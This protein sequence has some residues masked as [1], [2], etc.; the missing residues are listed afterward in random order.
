MPLLQTVLIKPDILEANGIRVHRVVQHPGDFIVNFPGKQ[1]SL[2]SM[3]LCRPLHAAS[4]TESC[5]VHI[6]HWLCFARMSSFCS[7]V[8]Q[9]L[10]TLTA[11]AIRTFP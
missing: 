5:L 7:I 2:C 3:R 6:M 4:A 8:Q 11:L 1:N 10:G 9:S